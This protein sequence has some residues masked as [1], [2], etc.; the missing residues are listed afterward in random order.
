[1]G[2]TNDMSIQPAKIQRMEL[3]RMGAN[4]TPVGVVRHTLPELVS[5]SEVLARSG[6][7]GTRRPDEMLALMLLSQAEGRDAMACKGRWWIWSDNQGVHTQRKA[8]SLLAD[9]QAAGGEYDVTVSTDKVCTIVGTYRGKKLSVTW[10]DAKVQAAGLAGRETHKKYP[11]KMKF[12][13]AAKDLVEMLAPSVT[14]GCVAIDETVIV[15]DVSVSGTDVGRQ[16]EAPT[17][18]PTEPPVDVVAEFR[19]AASASKKLWHADGKPTKEDYAPA[20]ALLSIRVGA[21]V[22]GPGD[23]TADTLDLAREVLALGKEEVLKRLAEHAEQ[24]AKPAAVEAEFEA[25][26]ESDDPFQDV[27]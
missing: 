22:N 24:A 11:A 10:D 15:G 16:I 25:E 9:F 2:E 5:L 17:E 4:R 27:T 3:V 20:W 21:P 19:R 18:T 6:I 26:S 13:R 7:F 12:H 1:M 8:N 23:I 14:D